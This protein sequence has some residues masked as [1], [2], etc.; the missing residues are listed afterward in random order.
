[1]VSIGRYNGVAAARAPFS[2]INGAA[3][4]LG[5]RAVVCDDPPA[6]ETL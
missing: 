1:M 3:G 5:Y 6:P 2:R 4:H